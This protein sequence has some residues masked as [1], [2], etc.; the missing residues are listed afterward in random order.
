MPEAPNGRRRASSNA[1]G[2]SLQVAVTEAAR[3]Y[4]QLLR[5]YDSELQA[6]ILSK[7]S[8][9]K[10]LEKKVETEQAFKAGLDQ[11]VEHLQQ[12]V[13]TLAEEVT[14]LQGKLSFFR[15]MA[16][17][18]LVQREEALDEIRNFLKCSEPLLKPTID[19]IEWIM[20]GVLCQARSDD[21]TWADAVVTGSE[22]EN[23]AVF[24]TVVYLGSSKFDRLKATALRPNTRLDPKQKIQKARSSFFAL[25]MW[26]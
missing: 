18:N 12:W 19:N 21:G 9:V 5:Q 11:T 10:E 8:Q 2:D 3:Q 22:L 1:D 14:T 7:Q 25:P 6:N 17:S 4:E 13:S 15:E 24:Y 23:K 20:P 26:K 16:S